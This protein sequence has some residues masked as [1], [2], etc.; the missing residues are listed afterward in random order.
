MKFNVRTHFS[1][2]LKHLVV[3]Y[4]SNFGDICK[5]LFDKTRW[6]LVAFSTCTYTLP[7]FQ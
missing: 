4:S 2:S 7:D 6:V 1:E 5:V 3:F